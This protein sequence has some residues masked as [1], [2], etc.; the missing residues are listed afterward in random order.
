MATYTVDLYEPIGAVVTADTTLYTA[1]NTIWPTADGGVLEGATDVL[2]AEVVALGE[3][4][5]VE[6]AAA[7]DALDAEVISAV[8][9]VWGGAR[10]PLPLPEPV[11]GYGYGILPQLEGEAF[12]IVG[13]PPAAA[14]EDDDEIA[15]LLITMLA[16]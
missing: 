8:A 6:A 12:G 11:E 4:G 13:I 10:R 15:A 2:D 1:D 9:P 7:A 14:G 3:V 5:I 16:A